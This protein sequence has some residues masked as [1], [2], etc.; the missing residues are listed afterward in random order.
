MKWITALFIV[1]TS[2]CAMSEISLQKKNEELQ[3]PSKSAVETA[4]LE[5]GRIDLSILLASNVLPE[6][7]R[8]AFREADLDSDG[9]LT[10]E[11]YD[12]MP[13]LAE[14]WRKE[15]AVKAEAEARNLEMQWR[16]EALYKQTAQDQ[17]C[18]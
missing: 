8:A 3:S 9:F 10:P 2:L 18:L 1:A 11:E 13:D 5:D 14:E 12:N 4:R 15:A 7:R 6:E 17:R 16:L